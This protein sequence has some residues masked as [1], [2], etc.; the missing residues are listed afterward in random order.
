MLKKVKLALRINHNLLDSEIQDTIDTAR[1]ELVRSGVLES[2]AEDVT[3]TLISNAIRTYC[4]YTYAN[5]S[6]MAEGYF[7]SWQYQLDN[8]RKTYNYNTEEGEG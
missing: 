2:R 6:K 8:L 3:D 1:A 5:D 4:L 7:K